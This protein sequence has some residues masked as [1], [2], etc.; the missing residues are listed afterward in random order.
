MAMLA[1]SQG[2]AG[3]PAFKIK[4]PFIGVKRYFFL[5]PRTTLFPQARR[6]STRVPAMAAICQG[7]LHAAVCTNI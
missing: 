3:I 7:G 1:T 5:P 6:I 2:I 4:P